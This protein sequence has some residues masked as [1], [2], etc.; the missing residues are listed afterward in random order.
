VAILVENPSSGRQVIHACQNSGWSVPEDVAVLSCSDD[1][2]LCQISNIPI[3]GVAVAAAEIGYEAAFMLDELMKNRELPRNLVSMPPIGV[4]P[5]Q[6][7]N[8]LA[9]EDKTLADAVRF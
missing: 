7:T 4:V 6:S 2:L 9:V 5:R 3:S 8:I 1:E